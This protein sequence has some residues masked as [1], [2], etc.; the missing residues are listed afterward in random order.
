MSDFR[1]VSWK[2]RVD[3]KLVKLPSHIQLKFY[4]WVRSIELLGVIKTRLCPGFHDE[5]LKGIKQGQRSVRLNRAYRAIYIERQ[6][7]FLEFLEVIE[8]NKHEY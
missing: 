2:N 5:P 4:A 7:G 3:K 8:V 6:D 1:K